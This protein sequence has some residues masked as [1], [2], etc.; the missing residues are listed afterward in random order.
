MKIDAK[1]AS[2]EQRVVSRTAM[3][4]VTLIEMMI[5][6]TIILIASAIFFMNMQPALRQARVTNA[7]NITLMAMRQAHDK[8]VNERRVYIVSFV[9]PGTI[10]LTQAATAVVTNTY[11]LP[12]D[13]RFDAE[14]GLPNTLA[15]TPDHFGIGG[16]AIDFDQNVTGG[17]KTQVYFQPDGSAQDI[18][19]N[20]NNGIIYIARPG[21]LYSSRAIT[22][23]GATGRLRG[24]RL[25][26][27]SGTKVWSKQ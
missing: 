20:I 9:A 5:V 11:T 13:I 27:N 25:Y 18:N 8:A 10:T 22:L 7:Y 21:E 26:N 24:W 23:W 3:R 15:T 16:T 17:V 2:P 4:G 19:S 14:P 12:T 6:L 1:S